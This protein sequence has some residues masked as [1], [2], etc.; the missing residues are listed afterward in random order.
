MNYFNDSNFKNQFQVTK[1]LKF[2][3]IPIGETENTIIKDNIV[4]KVKYRKVNLNK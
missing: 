3:L 4:E 1:T 2:K